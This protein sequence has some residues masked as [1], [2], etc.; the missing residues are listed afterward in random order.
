[1]SSHSGFANGTSAASGTSI[2]TRLFSPSASSFTASAV[3]G[4]APAIVTSPS[5][6]TPVAAGTSVVDLRFLSFLRCS[7]EI[8]TSSSAAALSECLRF[9]LA[10]LRSFFTA[11]SAS[12]LAML[13]GV[14]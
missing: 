8:S 9:F 3:S 1:M 7:L 11:A 13:D 14:C 2:F 4:A 5:S 12:D 10:S 6:S